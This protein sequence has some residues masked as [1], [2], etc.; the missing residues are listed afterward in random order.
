MFR[1]TQSTSR[2]PEA[3][4]LLRGPRRMNGRGGATSMQAARD[5]P[6]S[7]EACPAEPGK[8]LRMTVVDLNE[9]IPTEWNTL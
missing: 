7:F 8:H 3:A 4:A 2:H 1:S 9:S 5:G 6:S